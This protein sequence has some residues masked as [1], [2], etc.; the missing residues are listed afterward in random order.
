MSRT[1]RCAAR[2]CAQA[3]RRVHRWDEIVAAAVGE[4]L[5]L[6][7]IADRL[8]RE[9]RQDYEAEGFSAEVIAAAENR[10]EY[11]SEAAG[12]FRAHTHS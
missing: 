10:T 9:A 7:A 2:R 11:E 3:E 4:G 8:S 1:V 12:L 5:E 6:R